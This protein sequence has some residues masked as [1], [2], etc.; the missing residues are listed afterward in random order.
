MTYPL[1]FYVDSL[2]PNTAGESR[3]PVIRILKE[4]KDDTG[5][6]KHE[7]LH[8]KQWLTWSVLSIPLAYVLYN[9]GRIDFIGLAFLALAIHS[10]L[11][12]CVPAYRLWAEVEAYKE[13]AKHYSD[14]RR[15][16]F[17]EYIS[18]Y[19]NL[20]ITPEDALKRLIK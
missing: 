12:K 2:G 8:V 11:Y 1:T 13:Q 17:A 4:Y 5:I 10:T 3:G 19:Y 16:L 6:Y 15:A 9:I 20:K 18:A 14:D 7:L